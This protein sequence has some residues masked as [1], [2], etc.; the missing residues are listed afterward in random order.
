MRLP[1]EHGGY[2]GGIRDQRLDQLDAHF[3]AIDPKLDKIAT[4][5]TGLREDIAM[6]RTEIAELRTLVVERHETR[7]RRIT[8]AGVY[9]AIVGVAVTVIEFARH[10][11]R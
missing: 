5:Q 1:G 6:L 11:L 9:A 2:D 7:R 4:D 10:G 8:V 3:A